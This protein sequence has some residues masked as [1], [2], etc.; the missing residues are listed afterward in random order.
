M[1]RDRTFYT[2]NSQPQCENQ[3]GNA[4]MHF[5]S[6]SSF[7]ADLTPPAGHST[8]LHGLASH[9]SE[10]L[11]RNL[12]IFDQNTHQSQIM[13]HPAMARTFGG[14]ATEVSPCYIQ[15]NFQTDVNL[16]ER[17]MVL[18]KEDSDDIDALLSLEEEEED[19]YE[20]EEVSTARTYGSNSPDSYSTGGS[21]PL[22]NES[23]SY[24]SYGGGSS[25]KGERKRQKMK[26][27]V[28]ELRSIVPGGD[29]MNTVTILDEAVR[30]LKSLKFEVKKLGVGNFRN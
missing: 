16:V 10:V 29:Q 18:L 15:G 17:E 14:P 12:V 5:P 9:P 23:S 2:R 25:S 20:E 7:P 8:P 30:Y 27:M 26:M 19:D 6:S 1:Q 22:K 3:M 4:Y 24:K 11:P 28:K 21:K 13:F